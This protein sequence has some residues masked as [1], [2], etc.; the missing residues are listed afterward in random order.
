[1]ARYR[2]GCGI[3][4]Q[5]LVIPSYF[6]FFGKHI[7]Y[8]DMSDWTDP[9]PFIKGTIRNIKKVIAHKEKEKIKR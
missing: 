5:P 7:H 1:M 4:P 8:Q 2:K 9:M 6:A 3:A